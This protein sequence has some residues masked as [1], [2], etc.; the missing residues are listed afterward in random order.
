MRFRADSDRGCRFRHRPLV[1]ATVGRPRVGVAEGDVDRHGIQVRRIWRGEVKSLHLE[2]DVK[3]IH[4]NDAPGAGRDRSIVAGLQ[5]PQGVFGDV[6]RIVGR[7]GRGEQNIVVNGVVQVCEFRLPG[8]DFVV[9]LGSEGKK[10]EDVAVVA[11][12]IF[13]AFAV[14]RVLGCELGFKALFDD[15]G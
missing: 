11:M 1:W 5:T 2:H 8:G 9:L 14:N 13:D 7:L 4:F 6:F 3:G 12:G 10:R 15:A